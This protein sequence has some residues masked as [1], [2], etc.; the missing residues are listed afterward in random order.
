MTTFYES[1]LTWGFLT[2]PLHELSGNQL[3]IVNLASL[4]LSGVGISIF[5]IYLTE[6]R[7]HQSFWQMCEQP[8]KMS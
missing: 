3:S 7:L 5:L 8:D 6:Y 2:V 1:F 4:A